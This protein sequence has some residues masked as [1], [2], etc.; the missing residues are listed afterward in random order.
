ML[1][2]SGGLAPGY[3][4]CCPGDRLLLHYFADYKH[5]PLGK[6]RADCSTQSCLKAVTSPSP[7]IIY[8]SASDLSSRLWLNPKTLNQQIFLVSAVCR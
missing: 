6:N 4:L 5:H 3:P 7:V 2:N 1:S 8:P